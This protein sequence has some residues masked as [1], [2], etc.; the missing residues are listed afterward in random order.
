MYCDK[1]KEHYGEFCY[2]CYSERKQKA[3]DGYH[4]K[5][6]TIIKKI[7]IRCLEF[8]QTNAYNDYPMCYPC[9][10]KWEKDSITKPVG[11]CLF[12]EDDE[13]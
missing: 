4:K 5:R 2:E 3:I 13:N 1:H 9:F 10:C 11:I 12:I 7:C 6:S 8:F